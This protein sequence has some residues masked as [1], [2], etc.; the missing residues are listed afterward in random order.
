M[1]MVPIATTT[2]TNSTTVAFN[3]TDIPQTYKDLQIMSFAR[4]TASASI[5][6]VY[7]YFNLD[8]NA[9]YS[10]HSMLGNG[11]SSTAPFAASSIGIPFPNVPAASAGANIF[12]T[13]I[14][15]ITGYSNSGK[16][17]TSRSYG[18]VDLSGSGQ[19]MQTSGLWRSNVPISQIQISTGNGSV[20]FVAGS[21]FTLYGIVG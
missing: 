12:G 13:S 11:S 5:S 16:N 10:Q 21:R 8:F 1:T 19:I 3:F 15:T 18:G 6:T 7:Y 2:L 20:F 17:K 9:N 4:V 14:A